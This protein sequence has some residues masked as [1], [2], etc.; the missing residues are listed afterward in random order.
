VRKRTKLSAMLLAVSTTLGGAALSVGTVLPAHADYAPGPN[1]IVGVGSD[2]LQYLLDFGD[3]GDT[4]GDL[5]FNDAGDPYKI[6]SI[7]ATADANARAAYYNNSTDANL[8]PLDPTV[9][10]RGGTY[11]IER[12]NGSSAGVSALI[13]DTSAA[14][15]TIN[16]ARMS[17][18][19]TSAEGGAVTGGLEVVQIATENLEMAAYQ[20]GTNAPSGLS[21]QQLLEM[22]ECTVPAANGAPAGTWKALDSAD[23]ST[24]TIIPEI[25]Q[26]GSG[27]RSTFLS[28]L[29]TVNGGTTPTL[30]TCVQTVEE[31]DPTGITSLSTVTT[32]PVSGASTATCTP[33]CAYDAV[34]PFSGSR[35]NLWNGVSGDPTLSAS[36]GVGYFHS[37]TT[38][39]P[40][41]TTAEAPDVVLL[42]GKPSDGNPVFDDDRALNI[43]YPFNQNSSATAWQPGSKLNWANDLFCNPNYGNTPGSPI[44]PG[45]PEPFFESPAGQALIAQAGATPDY[46]CATTALT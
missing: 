32:N 14:D 36:S 44:V 24:D 19:P 17:S 13:A 46:S 16:F 33:N 39:Y 30:G 6:V 11:P 27:T 23:T 41:A 38:A 5:G 18:Q 3:D 21:L 25:P 26:A 34:D 22:Y 10:L 31:N 7:D 15:P 12:P 43:V 45:T 42:T 20:T 1:D 8:L 35:L 28:E 4:V 40:G 2:T 29:A 37:P 9:V